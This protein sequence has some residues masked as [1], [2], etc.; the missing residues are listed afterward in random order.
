MVCYATS[1]VTALTNNSLNHAAQYVTQATIRLVFKF[2]SCY[3][4]LYE[5]VWWVLIH[6]SVRSADVVLKRIKVSSLS[7][8]FF[9]SEVHMCYLFLLI[10]CN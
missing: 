4:C 1:P 6:L 9:S 10:G 3:L 2:V 8:L 5:F 7:T